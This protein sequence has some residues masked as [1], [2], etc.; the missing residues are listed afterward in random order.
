MFKLLIQCGDSVA[1]VAQTFILLYL[2]ILVLS[3]HFHCVAFKC[4]IIYIE[5]MFQC[6]CM[7]RCEASKSTCMNELNGYII[8]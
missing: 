2:F 6:Q 3:F 7:P 8:I 1:F 5:S 4:A